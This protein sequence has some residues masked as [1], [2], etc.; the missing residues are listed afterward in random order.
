MYSLNVQ[1]I[2]NNPVDGCMSTGGALRLC[3][4]PEH[5]KDPTYSTLGP[6]WHRQEQWSWGTCKT[7]HTPHPQN[8][9]CENF[10][11]VLG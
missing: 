4:N 1:M 2:C 10:R 8:K 3:C 9:D 6:V 11:G 7:H 5:Q